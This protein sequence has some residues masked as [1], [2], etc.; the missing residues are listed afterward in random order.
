MSLDI[1]GVAVDDEKKLSV[2]EDAMA[3]KG[4]AGVVQALG[5]IDGVRCRVRSRIWRGLWF[6]RRIGSGVRLRFGNNGIG[7]VV[8]SREG[9]ESAVDGLVGVGTG[10][11]EQAVVLVEVVLPLQEGA[12]STDIGETTIGSEIHEVPLPI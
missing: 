5:I 11:V 9:G 8:G 2:V 4:D 12:M 3:E 1:V 7:V 10:G 6:W